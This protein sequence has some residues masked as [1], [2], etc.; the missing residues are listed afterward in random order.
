MCTRR[1][2][3]NSTQQQSTDSKKGGEK[4]ID[5]ATYTSVADNVMR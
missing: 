4:K 3:H 2:V 5:T 1:S